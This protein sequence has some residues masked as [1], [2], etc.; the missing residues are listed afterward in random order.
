MPDKVQHNRSVNGAGSLVL[1]KSYRAH[2][3]LQKMRGFFGIK[4]CEDNGPDWACLLK[5]LCDSEQDSDCRRVV[6]GAGDVAAGIIVGAKQYRRH[7]GVFAGHPGQDVRQSEILWT[8]RQC[9][10]LGGVGHQTEI[11]EPIDDVLP[12]PLMLGRAHF[13]PGR[14]TCAPEATPTSDNGG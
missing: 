7:I 9:K 14:I 6:V 5:Y 10:R 3:R 4:E 13:A 8:V 12:R 11:G 1:V 2:C